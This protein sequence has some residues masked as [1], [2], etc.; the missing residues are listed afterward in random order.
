MFCG[1]IFC[2]VLYCY[3]LSFH[4]SFYNLLPYCLQFKIFIAYAQMFGFFCRILSFSHFTFFLDLYAVKNVSLSSLDF[5]FG[6]LA[7][8][9]LTRWPADLK[10][11]ATA[12]QE[13]QN[14]PPRGD[15]SE[16]ILSQLSGKVIKHIHFG[17]HLARG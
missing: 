5:H 9:F 17:R 12:A 8:T 11:I 2:S 15:S 3:Y 6:G 7:P 4:H 16:Y 10:F 13:S 14:C 1:D